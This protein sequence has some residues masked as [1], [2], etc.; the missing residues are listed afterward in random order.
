M[1]RSPE[2]QLVAR[3]ASEVQNDV[4]P[5]ESSS[6][7][8]AGEAQEEEYVV[9]E[10]RASR[11]DDYSQA[12]RYLVMWKGYGEEDK[13]WEPAEN[14]QNCSDLVRAFE[15]AKKA[16]EMR[17]QSKAE[18]QS[19]S[20]AKQ[21]L[22]APR[23]SLPSAGESSEDEG[24]S[25]KELDARREKAK[26]KS[27]KSG[28]AAPQLGRGE[29]DLADK[30]MKDRDAKGEKGEKKTSKASQGSKASTSSSGK[31]TFKSPKKQEKSGKEDKG[32]APAKRARESAEASTS[33]SSAA[34][35]PKKA[36]PRIVHSSSDDEPVAPAAPRKKTTSKSASR[37]VSA[38]PLASA[39]AP[40]PSNSSKDAAG[41]SSSSSSAQSPPAAPPK[42]AQPRP[43]AAASKPA[44]AAGPS[45]TASTSTPAPPPTVPQGM[46][47][48]VKETLKNLNFKKRAPSPAPVPPPTRGVRFNEQG[49]ASPAHG[50]SNGYASPAPH[51]AAAQQN[52]YAQPSAQPQAQPVTEAQALVPHTP[53]PEELAEKKRQ[54]MGHEDRLRKTLWC[55]TNPT[56][57]DMRTA[58]PLLCAQALNVE[59]HQIMR[60]KNR[61]VAV[62][63]DMSSSEQAKGEGHAMGYCLL[64]VGAETPNVMSK[65]Q[66]V[67]MHRSCSFEHIEQLYCELTGLTTHTVEFFQFGGGLPLT[68]IFTT[69]YLVVITR[70]A[71]QQSAA[72]ERFCAVRDSYSPMVRLVAHPATIAFVRQS[73]PNWNGTIG[74]LGINDVGVVGPSELQLG[75]AFVA[76]KT[77]ELFSPA[78]NYP[79]LPTVTEDSEMDELVKYLAYVRTSQPQAYRRFV[80]VSGEAIPDQKSRLRNR[81]VELHT[82]G[83]LTELISNNY[84]G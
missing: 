65:V 43:S 50:P 32:K 42:P 73:L 77:E 51:A 7:D 63:F 60:M 22:N 47:P 52:G 10:I 41:A 17:R 30:I 79:P 13:T 23:V 66:A 3:A 20:Q 27:R 68:P 83:S 11:W 9:E 18:G 5:S 75:T 72:L 35:K 12:W 53:T 14:L 31:T 78:Q 34:K 54:L 24:L 80:V 37:P 15:A 45:R 70:T 84:F 25:M 71:L 29:S 21:K 55:Q 74:L 36:T 57:A 8:E 46:P 2:P 38:A 40:P 56:F 48:M 1:P 26:K 19:S 61:G 33:S 16:R 62:L 69:G 64:A 28:S 4:P 82:W 76:V 67:C 6:E 44:P 81:G 59:P 49:S 39:A 58:L